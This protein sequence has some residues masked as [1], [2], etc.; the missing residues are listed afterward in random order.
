M[1]SS[2]NT[3]NS[4]ILTLALVSSI[5]AS[6]IPI[7]KKTASR[8]LAKRSKAGPWWFESYKPMS[9][10]YEATLLEPKYILE[11]MVRNL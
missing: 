6:V 10:A 2:F 4:L 3:L 8:H 5:T 9:G 7:T 1:I 11:N